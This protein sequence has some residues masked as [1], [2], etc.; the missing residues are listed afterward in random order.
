MELIHVKITLYSIGFRKFWVKEMNYVNLLL[1]HF[2]KTLKIDGAVVNG[3]QFTRYHRLRALRCTMV[4][5]IIVRFRDYSDRLYVWK[6]MRVIPQS[7]NFSLN[8]DFPKS[9]VH[10]RKKLLPVF[11]KARRNT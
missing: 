2:K 11:I 9:I 1:G 3:I 4:P 5:N 6:N 8:E 10:N 7:S